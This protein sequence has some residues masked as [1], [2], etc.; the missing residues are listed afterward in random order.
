MNRIIL[1]FFFGALS[2][3]L[4]GPLV[5]QQDTKSGQDATESGTDLVRSATEQLSKEQKYRLAY[6]LEEG[7]TIRWSVE[8]TASTETKIANKAEATS[9]RSNSIKVWTVESV[10]SLG[11]MTFAHSID[12]VTMWH[13]IG[14]D[15]PISFDSRE[16][17]QAPEEYQP[18]LEKV[19]RPLATITINAQG[20]VIDRKS[21]IKQARFGVGDV[22]LPLPPDEI[23][24]GHQWYVPSNLTASD[25]A[26]RRVQ[27][28]SRLHY[29]LTKVKN[30]NAFISF[31]TEVLS[32]IESEKVRSQIMQQ[33]TRG[34]LVFDMKRGLPIRK[35]VEWDEKV[36]GYE[37]PDSFLSYAAQLS[38]KIVTESGATLSPISDA[39]S[40][41]NRARVA[42]EKGSSSRRK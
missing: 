31:R 25:E 29:T 19:G 38:E 28:N 21:N 7:Q 8:H 3:L 20:Q 30:H 35:E 41:E 17:E 32:P 34:Y 9:S 23:A 36:H 22:T 26:G 16:P 2:T 1:A 5:A 39:D 27:L 18:V 40:A 24:V 33:M 15:D 14:E 42:D 4:A 37:G 6:R 11:N 13:Q 12:Q 10:D